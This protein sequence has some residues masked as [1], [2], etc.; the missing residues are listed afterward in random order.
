M[1]QNKKILLTTVYKKKV[2]DYFLTNCRRRV[3]TFSLPRV[4]S[5]GLRFIKQNIPKIE[6]LEYPTWK[7][8][9][10]KIDSVQC[11][12]IPQSTLRQKVLRKERMFL[13]EYQKFYI[14]VST[15]KGT[16]VPKRVP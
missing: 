4:L 6:V 9:M 11:N 13:K 7:E 15:N 8:Y 5:F 12:K 2:Y 14:R 1:V 16:Y 3:F 10:E